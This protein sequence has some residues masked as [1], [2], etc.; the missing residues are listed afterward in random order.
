M[1]GDVTDISIMI[2]PQFADINPDEWFWSI[3][4]QLKVHFIV[5]IN[6]VDVKILQWTLNTTYGMSY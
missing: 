4:P 2:C 1:P 6:R 5:C 3:F